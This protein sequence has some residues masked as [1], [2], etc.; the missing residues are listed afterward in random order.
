MNEDLKQLPPE[1]NALEIGPRRHGNAVADLPDVEHDRVADR[2]AELADDTPV[3][4]PAFLI[5]EAPD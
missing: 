2:H 4:A 3:S 5:A 1:S